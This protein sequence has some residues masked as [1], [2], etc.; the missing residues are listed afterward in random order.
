MRVSPRLWKLGVIRGDG[1][2]RVDRG[3]RG[4]WKYKKNEISPSFLFRL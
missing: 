1:G 3:D 2:D 4:D